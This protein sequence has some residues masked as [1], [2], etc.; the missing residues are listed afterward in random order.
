MLLE[1]SP[2]S[3]RPRSP[4][5]LRLGVAALLLLGACGD[6]T[7]AE[8]VLEI[9]VENVSTSAGITGT[10]G[11]YEAAISPGVL[12][13]DPSEPVVPGASASA[14]LETL[15]EEGD[16][17][18]YIV[19]GERAFPA[20]YGETYE[21]GALHPGEVTVETV[22]LTSPNTLQLVWMYA[23]ANDVVIAT[24]E[25]SLLDADGVMRTSFDVPCALY[26]VGTEVNEEPGFGEHQ[27]ARG[28]GGEEEDALIRRIEG[29]SDGFDY[30]AATE[31]IRVHVEVV[32]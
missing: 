30:P 25:F 11:S 31:V 28:E 20:E 17:I 4:L 18:D 19:A 8:T 23:A 15:A 21:G 27:P 6:E 10:S 3:A 2:N 22:R 29:S 1:M 16:P 13:V 7:T 12:L 32:G 9:T 26:D 5:P 14:A 24:D